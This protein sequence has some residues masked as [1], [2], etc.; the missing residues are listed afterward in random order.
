MAFSW[1]LAIPGVF[2][3]LENDCAWVFSG[4]RFV[5]TGIL[6]FGMAL[7]N[8]ILYP[9]A[10]YKDTEAPP[11]QCFCSHSRRLF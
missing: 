11:P 7:D 6:A 5:G 8:V 2:A 9:D 4:S 3:T 1:I 10:W